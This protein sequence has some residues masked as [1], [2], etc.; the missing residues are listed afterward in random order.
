M[1]NT[2]SKVFKEEIN[3][4]ASNKFLTVKEAAVE[5]KLKVSQIRHLI[6]QNLID[7]KL[8]NGKTVVDVNSIDELVMIDLKK[9]ENVYPIRN[10]YE[11]NSDKLVELDE[12]MEFIIKATIKDFDALK[13][14]KSDVARKFI[15][16]ATKVLKYGYISSMDTLE[17]FVNYYSNFFLKLYDKSPKEFLKF[18]DI[19]TPSDFYKLRKSYSNNNELSIC[20]EH[21]YIFNK[22]CNGK[23]Q[24]FTPTSFKLEEIKNR[25]FA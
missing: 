3:V 14:S 18:F 20:L 9:G 4:S 7:S 15:S 19:N 17:Y 16:L 2:T 13:E 21:F 22:L 25:H 8:E 6:S 10:N 24:M 1:K 5:L 12:E 11:F 23:I